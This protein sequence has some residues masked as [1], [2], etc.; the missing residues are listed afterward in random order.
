MILPKYMP[1]GAAAA[2]LC[3]HLQLMQAAVAPYNWCWSPRERGWADSYDV[4]LTE[5]N[6][7]H[8]V[9]VTQGPNGTWTTIVL[10]DI[11]GDERVKVLE[12]D[13]QTRLGPLQVH[14]DYGVNPC[15]VVSPGAATPRKHVVYARS[16]DS[17]VRYCDTSRLDNGGFWP[18]TRTFRT[19]EYGCDN[20]FTVAATHDITSN[21]DHVYVCFWDA[22]PPELPTG[23]YCA[24]S[25]DNGQTWGVPPSRICEGYYD[26]LSLTTRDGTDQGKPGTLPLFLSIIVS[27]ADC[28]GQ[29]VANG[30]QFYRLD[31]PNSRAVKK[32]VLMR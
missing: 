27:R 16:F 5:N 20:D 7:T 30:V 24:H 18:H 12:Y 6:G 11:T 4:G 10:N 29:G 26:R 19:S 14:S 32:A 1:K 2:L 13:G 21:Q 17:R 15:L 23:L 9:N 22:D 25:T 8:A 28:E 31:A 3:L